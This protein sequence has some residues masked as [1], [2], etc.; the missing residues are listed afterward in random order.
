VTFEAVTETNV[1][2]GAR[3]RARRKELGIPLADLATRVGFP[4]HQ[5]ISHIEAG[6]QDIRVRYV[7]PLCRA[8]RWSPNQLFGWGES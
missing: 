1:A 6:R 8:L 5:S 4:N 7:L 2:I 3:I